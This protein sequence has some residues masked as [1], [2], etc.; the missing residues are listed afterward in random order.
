MKSLKELV[1]PNG[2]RKASG[3]FSWILN[4]EKKNIYIIL[5][6]I[7]LL[8]FSL[9]VYHLDINQSTDEAISF[10]SAQKSPMTAIEENNYNPIKIVSAWEPMHPPLYFI[11]LH[12]FGAKELGAV[13]DY[14]SR[15]LSA[16]DARS[17]DKKPNDRIFKL[18][19]PFVFF[20]TLS[21]ILVFKIGEAFFN[22]RTGLIAAFFL[23]T[24]SYHLVYSQI[25]RPYVIFS[26]FTLLSIFF[27]YKSLQK[28]K[29]NYWIGFILSTTLSF[30]T[31]YHTLFIIFTEI[32]FLLIIFG[33]KK[34]NYFQLGLSINIKT[35]KNLT[36]SW[37]AI[38]ALSSPLILYILKFTFGSASSGWNVN[39]NTF[40]Y[41]VYPYLGTDSE[42]LNT[43]MV[44]LLRISTIF[45]VFIVQ[46]LL[47]AP[48]KIQYLTV[49]AAIVHLF[50][51]LSF[52]TRPIFKCKREKI[53]LIEP[54][55][56]LLLLISVSNLVIMVTMVYSTIFEPRL[57]YFTFPFYLVVISKGL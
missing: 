34:I 32:L 36:F 25:A 56:L 35:L 17:I 28:N 41:L 48:Y 10:L 9:R 46:W 38:L 40:N 53:L 55:I 22:S 1:A 24:S 27:F 15:V 37:L 21:I 16:G 26:F 30:Y 8:G 50:A 18:R 51:F 4:N 49:P 39:P 3:I 33:I 31:H 19:V 13:K 45:T 6:L 12:Y 23:S 47:V 29:I 14:S 43:L 52:V 11:I 44:N 2:T 57:Y 20:G 42:S 54:Y 7:L 5:F